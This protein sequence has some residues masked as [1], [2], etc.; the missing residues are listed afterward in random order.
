MK[1]LKLI[2]KSIVAAMAVSTIIYD[3]SAQSFQNTYFPPT[4]DNFTGCAAVASRYYTVGN[5][6]SS[7][8]VQSVLLASYDA[9]G[10]VLYQRIIY[11]NS[12]Q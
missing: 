2:Q 8:G 6:Q 7:Y 10:N 5:T 11:D 3:L 1:T 9:N 12:S 4:G